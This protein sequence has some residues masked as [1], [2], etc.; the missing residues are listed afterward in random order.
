[1]HRQGTRLSFGLMRMGGGVG[2]IGEKKM[3]VIEGNH[4][5]VRVDVENEGG[6]SGRSPAVWEQEMCQSGL[7]YWGETL[8]VEEVIRGSLIVSRKLVW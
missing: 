3:R 1:M 5:K 7:N 4:Q 2:G 8:Q 6:Q